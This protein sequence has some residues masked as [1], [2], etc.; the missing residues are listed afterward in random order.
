MTID[1]TGEKDKKSEIA[2]KE[3]R[4]GMGGK[5]QGTVM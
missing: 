1:G 4:F 2:M 3:Q 5:K